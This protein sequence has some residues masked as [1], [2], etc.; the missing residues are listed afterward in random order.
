[1]IVVTLLTCLWA[2]APTHANVLCRWTGFCLYLSPGFELTVVDAE[3]GQPLPDVY[4]WAEWVQ[5]GAHGRG[6]PLMVQDAISDENGRLTFPR[7]GPTLGSR[8]G[9]LLGIDPAV[10]LFKTGYTTLLIHNGVPPGASHHAAIRGMSRNGQSL[11]LQPF[12]GSPLDSLQNLR[13]LSHPSLSSVSDTQRDRF[14]ALYLK[15][16]GLVETEVNRLPSDAAEIRAFRSS[17]QLDR[18]FLTGGRR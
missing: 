17:L 5:Y 7:W 2:P 3:T 6:G 18:R 12:R 14:A 13:R 10:I 8:G 16:L 9:L 1:M 11:R 15:R 4:A